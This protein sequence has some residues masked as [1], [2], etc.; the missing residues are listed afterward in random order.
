[1]SLLA[2][3]SLLHTYTSIFTA[4]D[5]MS[6]KRT[7]TKSRLGYYECKRRKIKVCVGITG[8]W[9]HLLIICQ[10]DEKHPA[11]FNFSRYD[12]LCSYP[13]RRNGAYVSTQALEATSTSLNDPVLCT[14]SLQ[15]T[16]TVQR[17]ATRQGSELIPW[18]EETRSRHHIL[19]TPSF[20]PDRAYSSSSL[21]L[22]F[23]ALRGPALGD[24]SPDE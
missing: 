8:A 14:D 2:I 11:C 24:S 9:C 23:G 4:C 17:R 19:H 15:P 1:M 5:S 20:E 21:S 10:C 12:T 16:T 13:T 22:R 6:H 18:Q 7:H 3:C